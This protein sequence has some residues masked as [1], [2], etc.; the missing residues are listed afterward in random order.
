MTA[1]AATNREGALEEKLDWLPYLVGI[2]TIF[3]LF[4]FLLYPIGKSVLSSF[5][6]SGD[7]LEIANFTWLNFEKFFVSVSYQKAFVHSLVVALAA[8]IIATLLALPAAF[9]ISPCFHAVS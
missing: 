9:A 6:K 4:A 3:V 5:V 8:T 2:L 7:L 1:T